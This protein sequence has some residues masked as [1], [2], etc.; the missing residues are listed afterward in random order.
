MKCPQC[1]GSG[2]LYKH[3]NCHHSQ[4]ESFIRGCYDQSVCKS[5]LGTGST[6]APLIKAALLEIK[7]EST[8]C[9]SSRLAEKALQEF[10]F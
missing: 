3:K 6:G 8:D 7:L 2:L 10:E 4:E 1:E 5:C 9:N